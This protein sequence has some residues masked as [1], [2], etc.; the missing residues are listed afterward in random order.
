MS[1]TLAYSKF[2]HPFQ[3]RPALAA[4][5]RAAVAAHQRL[6]HLAASRAIERLA[7]LAIILVHGFA[8]FP[9]L[10]FPVR[11]HSP[12]TVIPSAARNLPLTTSS[13]ERSEIPRFAWNDTSIDGRGGG[14]A[15]SAAGKS[16]TDFKKSRMTRCTSSSFP[17]KK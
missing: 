17:V 4:N 6:N 1:S 10:L 7:F 3:R 12:S 11:P 9:G 16:G 5:H 13:T 14:A 2:I 8:S 15:Y